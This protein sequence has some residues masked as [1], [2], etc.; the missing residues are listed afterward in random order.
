[1]NFWKSLSPE[2][3]G[4]IVGFTLLTAGTTA[5]VGA[6]GLP[7]ALRAD[8]TPASQPPDDPDVL[9]RFE[10]IEVRAI[11]ENQDRPLTIKQYGQVKEIVIDVTGPE[12]EAITRQLNAV[13][14]ALEEA[15]GG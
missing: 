4:V 3:R 11:V 15:E 5:G 13:L 8:S 10:H 7:P 9:S 14:T 6:F 2:L 12:F 1:M